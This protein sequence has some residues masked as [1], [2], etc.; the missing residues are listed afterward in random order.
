MPGPALTSVQAEAGHAL[1]H[2]NIPSYLIDPTGLI[3]WVNCST[4]P[5]T[6]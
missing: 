2:I 6:A 3:R 5:E 1:E 4:S